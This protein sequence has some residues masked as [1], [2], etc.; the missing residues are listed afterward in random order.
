[1]CLI[2]ARIYTYV[3]TYVCMYV[4]TQLQFYTL[5]NA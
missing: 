1:M 2:C 5:A 3:Y 4:A